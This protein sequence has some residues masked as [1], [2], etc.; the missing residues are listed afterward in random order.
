MASA[1][2]IVLVVA[3]AIGGAYTLVAYIVP[4]RLGPAWFVTFWLATSACLG[5]LGTLPSLT[6]QRA[7][8]M[9]VTRVVVPGFYAT[10]IVAMLLILSVPTAVLKRRASHSN[11][12]LGTS[13][14]F[15]AGMASTIA[16]VIVALSVA[17]VLDLASILFIPP[18]QDA[19]QRA[20]TN[21]AADSEA[22]DACIAARPA[23]PCAPNGGLDHRDEPCPSALRRLP[24]RQLCAQVPRASETR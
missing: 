16:G 17:L 2:P 15:V 9:H 23:Q 10:F 6:L 20:F 3:C 22:M 12:L 8:G 14:R 13:R 11:L 21:A 4:P 7:A 5:A 1:G 18:R 24:H 19:D